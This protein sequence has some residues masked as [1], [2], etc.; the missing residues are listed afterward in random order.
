MSCVPRWGWCWGILLSC[1]KSARPEDKQDL[2]VIFSSANRLKEI[3]EE[4]SDVDHMEKGLARLRR[5]KVSIPS[6][7]QEVTNFSKKTAEEHKIALNVEVPSTNLVVE[8]DGDKIS[9]AL[10]NLVRNALTFTNEGG[11]VKVKA[12]QVPGYIKVSVMDNG[13]GI[14]AEE[15]QKIFQRFYQVEK[16]LTRRHGGMGLGLSIAKEMVEMHGGK[17]WVESVEGKGSK[18]MFFL[19]QNAAQANAAE[20]VSTQRF[21]LYRQPGK[22]R[23]FGEYWRIGQYRQP[24]QHGQSQQDQWPAEWKNHGSSNGVFTTT[25]NLVAS[26]PARNNASPRTAFSSPQWARKSKPVITH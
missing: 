19:P 16:H 3:I 15:Q 9:I 12:E 21:S 14:P 2:E 13:I 17:I 10:R 7:L 4:F 25:D 6:L 26:L 8:G 11:R 24:G 22:Y 1:S 18:F 20:R 5:K 23:K